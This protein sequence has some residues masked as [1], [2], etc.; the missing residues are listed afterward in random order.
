M[1]PQVF[2]TKEWADT[3]V[4]CINGCEHRCRYCYA[5][6]RATRFNRCTY[7]EWGTS[8]YH[9]RPKDIRKSAKKLDDGTV[10]FPSSHDVTPRFLD[11]CLE[12]IMKH[13]AVGNRMLIV[14]K[15]HP[16]CIYT[17]CTKCKDYKNQILFRFTI[18][19]FD[20]EI[21]SLWE[22]GAPSFWKRKECLIHA[23]H[24]G[25]ATSVSCEP[26]L[27]GTNVCHLF[28]SLEE[29][30]THSFW[31][32]KLNDIEKRVHDVPEKEVQRIIDGQTDERI[33]E[34]YEELKDQPKIRWKESFKAVL[35]LD[36]PAEPGL[37]I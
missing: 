13:L 8:F 5:A 20:D 4:N 32:G 28:H 24:Q 15:P 6:H 26:M 16:E 27:D 25:Y 35:G 3:T 31:I 2:G 17:I 19:A 10:M 9:V 11:A 30:I 37:D 7:E 33:R 22:P 14:S 34:I 23:F 29:Y 18:G 36:M 1:K 12:V 21:L